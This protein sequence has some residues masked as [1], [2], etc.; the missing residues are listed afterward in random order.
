MGVPT[1]Y[2]AGSSASLDQEFMDRR[3][4][5]HSLAAGVSLGLVATPFH[6]EANATDARKEDDRRRSSLLSDVEHFGRGDI[7]I[8]LLLPD[9]EGVYRFAADAALRGFQAAHGVNGKGVRV[10][11]VRHPDTFD[12]AAEVYRQLERRGVTMVVGPLTRTSVNALGRLGDLP[13][14]T[15]ALNLP[16][17]DQ[18]IPGNCI[19]FSLAIEFE[20]RQVA[21]V[22]LE[23]LAARIGPRPARAL[24]I[25]DRQP[26]SQRSAEAFLD[27]WRA[28]GGETEPPIVAEV[29]TESDMRNLVS[30]ARADLVFLA[31][32]PDTLRV[33]RGAFAG[34]LPLYGTS[35][36][37][38]GA[39]LVAETANLIAAP[40]LDGVRLVD[41]PWLL[42]PADPVVAAYPRSQRLPH[43]EMQRLYAFGIDAFRIATELLARRERFE[44]DG[45]T[46][47]LLLDASA[48]PRVIRVPVLGEYRGGIL[49]PAVA[50]Q[51]LPI[52]QPSARAQS[53]TRA[54]PAR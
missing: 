31:I 47:R 7:R 49:L 5:L 39:S 8:A 50:G 41:M 22:A 15:L 11:V 30:G 18:P 2:N 1:T 27:A 19:L 16:D 4:V 12:N 38:N 29:R 25:S 23:D 33:V 14:P 42:Q 32:P 51:P 52:E 21:G 48:D 35:R 36:L 45:V 10:Q 28:F 6:G 9:I 13:L 46:G 17:A 53:S 3:R 20:G 40:E 54:V 43:L 26:L 34:S 37:N 24:A 44:L